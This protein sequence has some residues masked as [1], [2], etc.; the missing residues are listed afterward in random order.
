MFDLVVVKNSFTEFFEI[1]N[2]CKSTLEIQL[3]KNLLLEISKNKAKS[4]EEIKT[5]FFKSRALNLDSKNKT[6][7]NLLSFCDK[8]KSEN[9]NKLIVYLI[10]SKD[11]EMREIYNA[12]FLDLRC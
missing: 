6:L 3:L 8:I 12:W 4:I 5:D 11:K 1:K 9:G 7:I 10:N 2:I